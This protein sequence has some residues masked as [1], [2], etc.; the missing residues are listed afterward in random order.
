MAG[1]CLMLFESL[2][3]IPG[4]HPALQGLRT[5]LEPSLLAFMCHSQEE[6][7]VFLPCQPAAGFS[8][9]ASHRWSGAALSLSAPT[10]WQLQ[11][12][13]RGSASPKQGHS[14]G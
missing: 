5:H 1:L 2:P 7:Q 13:G 4:G 11:Q 14:H 10:P 9:P 6:K 12:P 3:L 8:T